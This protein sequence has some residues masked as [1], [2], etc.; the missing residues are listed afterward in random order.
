ML[1][2][3]SDSREWAFFLE[4]NHNVSSVTIPRRSHDRKRFN[5]LYIAVQQNELSLV[6]ELL[7]HQVGQR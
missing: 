4:L 3:E 1:K 6:R 5:E 2:L 7:Q